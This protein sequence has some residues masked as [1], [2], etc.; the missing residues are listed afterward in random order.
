MEKP[1]PK[2][3]QGLP[4]KDIRKQTTLSSLTD[5]MIFYKLPVR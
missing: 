1:L 3:R 2:F 4:Y 5:E